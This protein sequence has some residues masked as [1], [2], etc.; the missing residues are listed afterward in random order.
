MVEENTVAYIELRECEDI[1]SPI[2]EKV[3]ASMFAGDETYLVVSNLEKTD[4]TLVLR[5]EWIDR[6]DGTCGK[7][8]IL[9]P[10][11]ILFLRRK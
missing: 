4:Y 2:P 9:P 8:F 5:D 11:S 1:L 6:V 10:T 3:F 7:Q